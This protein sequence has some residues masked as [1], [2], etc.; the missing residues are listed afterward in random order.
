VSERERAREKE[1]EREGILQ[2]DL[3][4]LSVTQRH[5]DRVKEG[6]WGGEAKVRQ[7]KRAFCSSTCIGFQLD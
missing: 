1:V 5:S 6:V 3:R 2:A 7:T 4:C